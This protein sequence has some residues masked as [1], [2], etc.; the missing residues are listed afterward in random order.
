MEYNEIAQKFAKELLDK[1]NM[2]YD[3]NFVEGKTATDFYFL[4]KNSASN[5]HKFKIF[6]KETPL[7]RKYE[8]YE[9]Y[10]GYYSREC[11]SYFKHTNGGFVQGL[12]SMYVRSYNG[13]SSALEIKVFSSYE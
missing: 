11:I 6:I 4:L 12:H 10:F 2:V 3:V 13:S 7:M 9:Y 1:T 5:G 8:L